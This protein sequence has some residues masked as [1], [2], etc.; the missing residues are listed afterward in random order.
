VFQMDVAKVDRDV[1]YIAM[2]VLVWCNHN[3]S[4]VFSGVFCKCVYVDFVY[5]FAYIL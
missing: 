1:S 4:S 5:V 3:V 2:V